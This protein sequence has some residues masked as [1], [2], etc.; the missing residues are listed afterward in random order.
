MI[1]CSD[2]IVRLCTPL[3]KCRWM[4]KAVPPKRASEAEVFLADISYL[5][6]GNDRALI[7]LW[8]DISHVPLTFWH[9]CSWHG[10]EQRF[11]GRVTSS[12]RVTSLQAGPKSLCSKSAREEDCPSGQQHQALLPGG[13]FLNLVVRAEV[14]PP[15]PLSLVWGRTLS[16]P[17]S[18]PLV[19]PGFSLPAE[20][21]GEKRKALRV[22]PHLVLG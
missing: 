12:P 13:A 21:F 8:P 11:L 5:R 15:P 22:V 4:G 18:F 16:W 17:H 9:S 1:V 14:A 19:A 2:F 7:V 20:Y 10:R 3:L 6:V